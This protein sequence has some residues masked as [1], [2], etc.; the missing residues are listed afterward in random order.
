MYDRRLIGQKSS[1]GLEITGISDHAN[2]RIAERRISP[3]RILNMLSKEPTQSDV[4]KNCDVYSDAGSSVVIDRD[5]GVIVTV[6]WA[7]ERKRGK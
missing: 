2:M 1:T 3:N 5:N 7:R 4:L 6:M